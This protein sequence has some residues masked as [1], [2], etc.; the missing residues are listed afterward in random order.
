M[1]LK[2]TPS[3]VLDALATIRAQDIDAAVAAYDR[4]ATPAMRG[5]LDA[6]P[7]AAAKIDAPLA[8]GRTLPPVK[9]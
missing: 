9:R 8:L 7:S 1:A 3:A 2:P 6:L 5:L 4:D